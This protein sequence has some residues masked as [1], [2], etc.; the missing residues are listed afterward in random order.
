V[1]ELELPPAPLPELEAPVCDAAY[2][3]VQEALS[4]AIEH[5]HASRVVVTVSCDAERL[6]VRVAD[7]GSGFDLAAALAGTPAPGRGLGLRGMRDRVAAARGELAV[8]SAPGAGTHI[9][10]ELPL[11]I[12]REPLR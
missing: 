11:R 12:P 10:A 4:N 2:R 6:F 3:L 9:R 8:T 1:A 5:G 7:D